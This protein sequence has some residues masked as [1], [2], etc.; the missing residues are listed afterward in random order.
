MWGKGQA[1]ELKQHYEEHLPEG[2][3]CFKD[4]LPLQPSTLS[5][6]KMVVVTLQWGFVYIKHFIP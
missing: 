6:E 2:E 1:S 3:L 5:D 4:G